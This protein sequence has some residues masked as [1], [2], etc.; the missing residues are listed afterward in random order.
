MKVKKQ[1]LE[2]D[3]K[4]Q[5]GSKLGKDYNKAVYCHCLFNLHAEHIMWNIGLDES[6][7]EIKIS[8]RNIN[9][10]RYAD[11]TI[12]MA[13][14]EEELKGLLMKMKEGS[15]KAGLKLNIQ[16]TKSVSYMIIYMFQCYSLRSS[17]PRLLPQSP[18]DCS[19]HLYL[20]CCLAYRVIITIF[21]NS[22]YVLVYC[23]GV[24]LS[25]LLHSV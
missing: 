13:E 18:K 6:Q 14:R 11:D 21:L 24:F 16:E 17:Q 19:I 22:I 3:V 8:R 10:L 9:N 23:I 2:Q 5:T 20:F 25:G 15:R 12:L 1:Q 7:A 4:H